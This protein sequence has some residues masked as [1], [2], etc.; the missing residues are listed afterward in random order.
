MALNHFTAN[1]FEVLMRLTA[2]ICMQFRCHITFIMSVVCFRWQCVFFASSLHVY[3][4]QR[5]DVAGEYFMFTA[6]I[7]PQPNVN[8]ILFV[9]HTYNTHS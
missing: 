1:E 7:E 3:V 9:T 5:Y 4:C 6:D 2:E 8:E